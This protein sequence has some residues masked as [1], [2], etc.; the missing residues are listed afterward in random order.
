MAKLIIFEGPDGS[1]KTT[2]IRKLLTASNV[3]LLDFPK[4]DPAGFRLDIKS[5]A[6]VSCFETMLKY[7]SSLYQT[8]YIF[9]CYFFFI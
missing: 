8:F 9:I 3:R 7:L 6:E 1:G 2:L 4:K 5:R